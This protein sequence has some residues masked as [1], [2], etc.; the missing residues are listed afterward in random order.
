VTAGRKDEDEVNIE[1]SLVR[2]LLA[3]QFPRRAHL[4]VRPVTLGRMD[5]R[6]FRLGEDPTVRLATR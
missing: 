5:N 4:P 2:R 6:T 3:E 1:A